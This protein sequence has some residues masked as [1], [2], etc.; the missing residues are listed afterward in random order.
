[1]TSLRS[2]AETHLCTVRPLRI[3]PAPFESRWAL[4]RDALRVENETDG[5]KVWLNSHCSV[6]AGWADTQGTAPH[7]R[8]LGT[9]RIAARRPYQ[10]PLAASLA[11]V[12]VLAWLAYE[13]VATRK[14]SRD[15][16]V[17]ETSNGRS[18][19]S[20][21]HRGIWCRVYRRQCADTLASAKHEAA[22]NALDNVRDRDVRAGTA[23]DTPNEVV[24][25]SDRP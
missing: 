24:S 23:C 1:L 25:V 20:E 13:T 10:L 3:R 17:S 22:A 9:G 21:R 6:S 5:S 2:T 16:Q 4:D 19:Q 12:A 14:Q 18:P 11:G 15:I 7:S 8:Q